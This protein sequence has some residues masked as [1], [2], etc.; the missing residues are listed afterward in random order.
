MAC[1][2]TCRVASCVLL[3]LFLEWIIGYNAAGYAAFPAWKGW[4][5]AAGLGSTGYLMCLVH[6]QLFWCVPSLYGNGRW[7]TPFRQRGGVRTCKKNRNGITK[8]HCHCCRIGMRM[9]FAMRQQSIAA[10]YAKALRL[11]SSSIADVSP[12]KVNAPP[13]L[14]PICI[15]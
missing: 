8:L 7:R 6:H 14:H 12:G 3:K 11:N 9:G 2:G 4:A 15:I 13:L 10:V 5:I 1:A